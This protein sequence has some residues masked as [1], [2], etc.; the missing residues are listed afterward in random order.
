M[1]GNPE[2]SFLKDVGDSSYCIKLPMGVPTALSTSRISSEIQLEKFS[3]CQYGLDVVEQEVK[4]EKDVQVGLEQ[5]V[6]SE[7][8]DENVNFDQL[9]CTKT[10]NFKQE[11][12]VEKLILCEQ[13]SFQTNRLRNLKNHI[14]IVHEKIRFLCDRCDYEAVQRGDLRRHVAAKHD[15]TKYP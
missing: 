10:L 3:S 9:C 13:C 14:D 1:T 5:E 11:D 12:E 4:T 7:G 6:E 15:G 2:F 8:V